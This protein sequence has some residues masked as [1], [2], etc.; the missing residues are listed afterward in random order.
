[1]RVWNCTLV[2]KNCCVKLKW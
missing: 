2:A 1:M